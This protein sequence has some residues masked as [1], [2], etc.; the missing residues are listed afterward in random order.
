MGVHY[1]RI[2]NDFGIMLDSRWQM[3]SLR[4]DNYILHALKELKPALNQF[5]L[6]AN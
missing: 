6:M 2:E 5:A 4:S 1:T 3:P